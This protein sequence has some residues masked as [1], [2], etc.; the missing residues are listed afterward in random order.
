L[1][2]KHKLPNFSAKN[3]KNLHHPNHSCPLNL[4]PNPETLTKINSCQNM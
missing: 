2:K 1:H 4:A 3:K